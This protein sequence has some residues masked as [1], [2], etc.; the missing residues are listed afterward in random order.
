LN[1]FTFLLKG[2]FTSFK[3]G[4]RLKPEKKMKTSV[5]IKDE[6]L[7]QNAHD[8]PQLFHYRTNGLEHHN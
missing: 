6:W 2:F 3:L 7:S 1:T 8:A 5:V 4:L